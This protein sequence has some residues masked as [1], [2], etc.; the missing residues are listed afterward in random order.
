MGTYGTL[1]IETALAL[2]IWNRRARPWVIAGCVALHL[3]VL[4]TIVV[5]LFSV[6][7][8]VGYL[9]FTPPEVA[10]RWLLALRERLWQAHSPALRRIAAAGPDP[11]YQPQLP[12]GTTV[13][14]VPAR[15]RA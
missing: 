11:S 10:T 4:A 8:F 3:S 5:G 15:P 13:G 2:F 12:W 1:A 9:A 6:T 7:V 14:S